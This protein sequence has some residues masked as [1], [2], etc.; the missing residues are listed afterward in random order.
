MYTI[1]RRFEFSAS[2]VLAGLPPDHPCSRLHGHNWSV[3]LHLAAETTDATGFVVDFSE[4]AEFVQLLDR[5]FEHRHLNDVVAVSPTSEN[6]ARHFYQWASAR[7]PQVVACAVSET[8]ATVAVYAPGPTV[9][10]VQP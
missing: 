10:I 6:L 2:H 7:W 8:S 3:V 5:N 1:A 9:H 4:L